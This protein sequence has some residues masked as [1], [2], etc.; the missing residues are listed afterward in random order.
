[1]VK[2]Y[3]NCVVHGKNDFAEVF[4][5]LAKYISENNFIRERERERERERG[6]EREKERPSK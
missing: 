6:R 3:E 5:S 1:L 2:Q 4:K